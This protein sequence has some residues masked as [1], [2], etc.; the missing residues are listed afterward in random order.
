MNDIGPPSG[1]GS[2]L[3]R[4]SPMSFAQRRLWFLD[5]FEPDSALYN[6]ARVWRVR[7][8]LDVE[9]LRTASATVVARH[10]SLRTRFG[11]EGGEPVQIV[12]A[13]AEVGLAV[14]PC[15]PHQIEGRVSALAGVPFDLRRGP[16]LRVVLLRLSPLDHVLVLAI[17]HIVSDGWSMGIVAQELSLA[18]AA[19]RQGLMPAM[20]PLP[21]QYPDYSQ[22]QRARLTGSHLE[23]LLD[24]WRRQ[25][26]TLPQLDL[27]TDR[28]R[29]PMQSFRGAQEDVDLS[30]DLTGRLK[31]VARENRVTLYMV[32]L[33]A[34]GV[35]LARYSGQEDIV[36]GSPIAG[37]NRQDLEGLIG[38]FVNTLVLRL[39]LSGNPTFSALLARVRDSALDA[40]EH[41]EL[42]FERLV[43]ELAPA[44][45][46]SRNPI[47]QVLFS[48]QNV[49][50]KELELGG[51]AIEPLRTTS[52]AA[53][54]DL[55][56]L[57]TEA[58]GRLRGTLSYAT[59]LFDPA[60]TGGCWVTIADCW[61]TWS[62]SLRRGSRTSSS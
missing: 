20:N 51:L 5:Q 24:Y 59:D 45:D 43:E 9:A 55:V 16:L 42:P 7:G 33:A 46:L 53:K 31:A 44:R 48:L 32:L 3:E 25:L 58:D 49:P 47:V 14:E 1:G 13:S 62:R 29:P 40:Y 10:E 36:L 22:W 61:R 30:A 23:R 2:R 41:Q 11:V 39:D 37:R 56:L 18:Y 38:F 52:D 19:H 17:H 4:A 12:S 26:T 60:T 8:E 50:R 34:F 6:V 27:P 54:F 21:I 28:T 15:E 35:L 57:L